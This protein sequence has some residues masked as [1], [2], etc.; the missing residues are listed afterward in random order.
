MWCVGYTNASWTLRAD[1]TARATAKVD[2]IH[3]LARLHPRVPRVADKQ[4][5][6][7]LAWDIQAGYK[8]AQL[9]TCSL[10]HSPP[11]NVRQNHF[12]DAIDYNFV[13]KVEEDTTFGRVAQPRVPAG[14]IV[15]ADRSAPVAD[16]TSR[17]TTTTRV[18]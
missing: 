13:D 18:C 3:E 10:G 11:W 17:P 9:R 1:I 6:E 7:K 15:K 12:A 4:M 14:S 5:P 2:R 16:R 8:A